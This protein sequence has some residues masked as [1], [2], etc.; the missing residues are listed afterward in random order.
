MAP[1]LLARVSG[2]KLSVSLPLALIGFFSWYLSLSHH[3]LLLDVANQKVFRSSPSQPSLVLTYSTMPSL[4]CAALLYT[5]NCVSDL[6][7]EFPEVL[8]SNG[9]QLLHFSTISANIYS[10][11][12]VLLR[13][14]S[15]TAL[16]QINLPPPKL[17]F[18]PC[19]SW[20]L[21]ILPVYREHSYGCML[22][23]LL[24]W[25]GGAE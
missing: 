8:S 11:S 5:P 7:S 1:L 22:V 3:N 20:G 21:H 17:N 10:L 2:S 12:L 24:P 4:P 16:T 9:S 25:R 15:L 6:F 13:L 19:K 18:P 14:P 23:E